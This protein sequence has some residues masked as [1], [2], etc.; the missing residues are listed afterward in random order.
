MIRDLHQKLNIDSRRQYTAGFSGGARVAAMV[1]QNRADIAGVI[2]CGAG[3]QPA[4]SDRFHYVGM[5]G[6]E[7]FNYQ[8]I[9]SLEQYLQNSGTS[10]LIE[11]FDG[12]HDW[13]PMNTMA[14]GMRWLYFR[15]MAAGLVPKS[16]TAAVGMLEKVRYQDKQLR[17]NGN[18]Y[19]RWL[20]HK[21]AI[22]YLTGIIDVSDLQSQKD[23]LRLSKDWQTEFEKQEQVMQREMEMRKQ[24]SA[25]LANESIDY[26]KRVT[27]MMNK[28]GR[29]GTRED[30]WLNKRVLNF[31]SLSAFMNANAALQQRAF[32]AADRFVQIYA[33]V[34]P[35]NSEH[36]YLRATILM[37]ES[38]PD[39]AL[40]SLSQ[41]FALGFE[42]ADRLE[43]DPVFAP[44]RSKTAFAEL[45]AAIR[46]K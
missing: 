33:L 22:S 4:P 45:L 18:D 24:Y 15:E 27:T 20:L 1:A 11:Y 42:D 40:Q 31:L 13:A 12:G 2:G 17:T 10:H 41:A 26:W 30:A 7:D 3:Y 16:D 19:Q 37:Q 38:K 9:R 43:H 5:V 29:N 8:E 44:L 21:K 28:V 39:A 36:A 14:K 6:T 32:P 23:A 35:S 34:D 25:S 46:D